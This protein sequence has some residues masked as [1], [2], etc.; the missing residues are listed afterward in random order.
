MPAYSDDLHGNKKRG[1]DLLLGHGLKG[2]G[3]LWMPDVVITAVRSKYDSSKWWKG[4]RRVRD[5]EPTAPPLLRV[6]F[7][8]FS[9]S[10]P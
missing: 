5:S 2:A 10:K 6:P 8:A 1:L 7:W 4:E 3:H 9:L